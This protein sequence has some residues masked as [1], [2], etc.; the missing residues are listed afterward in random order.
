M[1]TEDQDAQRQDREN[2]RWAVL[3]TLACFGIFFFGL[4]TFRKPYASLP[5]VI[6]HYLPISALLWIT[7]YVL[8]LRRRGAARGL[9]ALAGIFS[10][11]VGAALMAPDQDQQQAQALIGSLRGHIDRAI[12]TASID[13]RD[14]ASAPSPAS[15]DDRQRTQADVEN[16]MREFVD[17]LIAQRGDYLLELEAIGWNTILDSERLVNDSALA[18]S[19]VMVQRAKRIVAK[20]EGRAWELMDETRSTITSLDLQGGLAGD[21]LRAF[22]ESFESSRGRLER[23]WTLEVEAVRQIESIVMLLAASRRW[24]VSGQEIT[25]YNE[26]DLHR[27]NGYL[28]RLQEIKREQDG[29][30]QE[31]IRDLERTFGDSTN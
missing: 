6:A 19:K 11:V 21:M 16:F 26:G 28:A 4:Q 15:R 14:L 10:S 23:Q 24:D 1:N 9:I 29:I 8:F 25:F 27:F 22:D 13:R 3:L 7:F 17:R 20:Y 18:E 12:A 31:S 5:L 2:D 30:A